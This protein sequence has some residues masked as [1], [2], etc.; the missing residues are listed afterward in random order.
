MEVKQKKSVKQYRTV[1]NSFWKKKDVRFYSVIS[2]AKFIGLFS[3]CGARLYN[4]EWSSFVLGNPPNM[5]Y[6]FFFAWNDP[7]LMLNE[8]KK[9]K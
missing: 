2:K 5:V 4:F 1:F 9:E 8:K 3:L 6:A 7:L